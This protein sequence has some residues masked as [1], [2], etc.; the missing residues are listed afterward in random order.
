M[1]L[2]A[3]LPVARFASRG[4]ETEPLSR[5]CLFVYNIRRWRAR[6]P[7]RGYLLWVEKN[8]GTF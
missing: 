4:N 6:C 3:C 2:K 8:D 7:G 5:A 1:T